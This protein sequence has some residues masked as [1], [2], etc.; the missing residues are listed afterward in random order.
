MRVLWDLRHSKQSAKK[1]QLSRI[2]NKTHVYI[3]TLN[4]ESRCTFLE[5]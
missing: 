3:P 4:T 5:L 2:M 1:T